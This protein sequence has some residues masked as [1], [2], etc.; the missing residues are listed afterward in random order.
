MLRTIAYLTM[1]AAPTD[2]RISTPSV[3]LSVVSSL[4][5][6]LTVRTVRGSKPHKSIRYAQFA[7]Y[8]QTAKTSF[9]A[10]S[11]QSNESLTLHT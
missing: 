3:V 5:F 2:L 11:N 8:G 1:P 4:T 7:G 9:T 6:R 10:N